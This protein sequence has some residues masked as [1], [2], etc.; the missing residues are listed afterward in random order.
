VG[1]VRELHLDI[2][3][4][5]ESGGTGKA[6]ALNLSDLG[7]YK[8]TI[9]TSAAVITAQENTI[10]RLIGS[11][12]RTV[13]LPSG[14][15]VKSGA[16]VEIFIESPTI[17]DVT[18]TPAEL[19]NLISQGGAVDYVF[20]GLG[21]SVRIVR[22]SEAQ[23]N[24]IEPDVS[25][26]AADI[27][28]TATLKILTATE[29]TK[30]AGI[31]EGAEVNTVNSVAGKTGDV[32][33][34]ADD[35]SP[36]S[37]KLWMSDTQSSKLAG[38]AEGA[39]NYTH[40]ATHPQ[41]MIEGLADALAGKAPLANPEFTGLVKSGPQLT[42]LAGINQWI[43]RNPAGAALSGNSDSTGRVKIMLPNIGAG[44][45]YMVSVEIEVYDYTSGGSYSVIADGFFQTGNWTRGDAR[46]VFGSI[47]TAKPS[48]LVRFGVDDGR[49][50]ITLENTTTTRQ[51]MRVRV[52]RVMISWV[53]DPTPFLGDWSVSLLTADDSTVFAITRTC[54]RPLN[55]EETQTI[56]GRQFFRN[57]QGNVMYGPVTP[58]AHDPLI[59]GCGTS[60]HW[61]FRQL[62]DGTLSFYRWN[63]SAW[64]K[65]MEWNPTTKSL[66]L[67]NQP[68]APTA[69]AGTNTTQI[70][71]T[72][73]V[74]AKASG[75]LLTEGT[76]SG[77]T[78][79]G[80]K[81]MVRFDADYFYVCTATNTW[82]RF[83]KDGSWT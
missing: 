66:D 79:T 55:S 2:P 36:T 11:G 57:A 39:N 81:G 15:A 43:L 12:S 25:L 73:F 19:E 40:P 28:E 70:A 77:P 22:V 76:P 61:K 60:D 35:V 29:R 27:T 20:T 3:L 31:A 37:T 42:K 10:Y 38:I 67:L 71:T 65:S 53:T 83:K 26:T 72:A 1:Y 8:A 74:Q 51:A 58:T 59:F 16:E 69:A 32:T 23:W 54:Y 50:V 30:L 7:A 68:T 21:K 63:G 62:T 33:L 75:A 48:I 41:S 34:D 18:I 52:P 6:D 13:T 49:G 9:R 44:V 46:A 47:S 45:A 80:T 56:N 78:A 4:A 17:T 24:V 82:V 64:E 14:S 5:V